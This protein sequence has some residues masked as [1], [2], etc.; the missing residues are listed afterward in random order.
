MKVFYHGRKK[1]FSCVSVITSE[2]Y[3][4]QSPLVPMLEKEIDRFIP[5]AAALVGFKTRTKV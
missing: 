3:Q 1:S 2:E 5:V 4:S